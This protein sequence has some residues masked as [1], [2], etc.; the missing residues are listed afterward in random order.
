MESN[1]H[2][3]SKNNTLLISIILNV[4]I[5]ASQIV[6]GILSN[7][8]ALISDAMHNF[9]DVISLIISYIAQKLKHKKT[10]SQRHTFG[11]K[12]AEIIAAF[13]NS[14]ILVVVGFYIFKEA[15]ENIFIKKQSDIIDANIVIILSIIGILV[16]SISAL[17]LHKDSKNNLNIKSSYLH[18]L[19]DTFT[20]I[21]VLIG[22]ILMSYFEN[23]FWIDSL[24]S[25]IVAIYLIYHS[26][27]IL[28]KT[29]E[30]LMQF[31]PKNLNGEEIAKEI[32][33]KLEI[34]NIFHVHIWRLDEDE[35]HFEARIIYPKYTTLEDVFIIQDK[36][37]DLLLKK[38]NINHITL[39][40]EKNYIDLNC[41]DYDTFIG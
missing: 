11:Y 25:I 6:G 22:G 21:G 4:L 29:L 30:I 1:H 28:I 5:T 37:S 15:I 23:I 33:S 27:D 3:N 38:Y 9:S 12:R 7:S 16:N 8:L 24:I 17:L 41:E 34:E 40:A 35:I 13:V 10:P 18:L 26:I 14:F 20:S 36:V 39:Q 31:T 2:H 19:S 32:K